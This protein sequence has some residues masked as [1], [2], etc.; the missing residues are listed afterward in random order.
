[1]KKTAP[2]FT[3]TYQQYLE[4]IAAI[5]LTTV[6]DRINISVDNQTA[7]IP[8]LNQSFRVSPS[9]IFD[10]NGKPAGLPVCVILSRYLLMAPDI[11]VPRNKWSAFRDFPGSGPLTVY[12]K[13]EV[14]MKITSRF[15]KDRDDLH[16]ACRALRGRPPEEE[17]PYDLSQAFLLLPRISALLLFN[18]QDDEFPASCSVLFSRHADRYLDIESLAILGSFFAGALQKR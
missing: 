7:V 1:M 12:W 6:K 16:R 3:E 2:V 8:L 18:Q 10:E 17:F 5:D 14:E 15:S 9:G 4:K 11:P 13:N